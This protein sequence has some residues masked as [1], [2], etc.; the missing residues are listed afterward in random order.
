MNRDIATEGPAPPLPHNSVFEPNK[1][2]KIQFQTLGLSLVM[3]VQKLSGPE[4]SQFLPCML[5]FL[6]NLLWLF[7]FSIYI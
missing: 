4:I 5:Q 2:Q 6:D 1:V 3:D 7:I